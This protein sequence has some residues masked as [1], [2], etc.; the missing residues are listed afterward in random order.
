MSTTFDWIYLG[1]GVD[2][3]SNESNSSAD[4]AGA[5]VG[6]TYGTT[7][8]PLFSHVT[9]AT[10]LGT[11]TTFTNGNNAAT[12]QFSTD[13]GSGVQAYTYDSN[14]VYNATITY[15][16]GTTATVTAVIV[17]STTGQLFMAPDPVASTDLAPYEAKPI[18]AVTFNSVANSTNGLATDRYVTG[19]DDGYV[20]GTAGSDL[21]NASYV[22]PVANGTDKIDNGDAGL[23]GSSGNDD[24]V[25][26]GAGNDTVLSG[27]GNDIV[28]GG[29]ENDSLS[30]ETGNDT[31][32]G[33][34]GN[35]TVL[36]GA[37]ADS[38]SG[39]DGADSLD[40][41]TEGDVLSG[42]AGADTLRGGAGNDSLDGGTEA[43]Q[44]FGEAGNDTLRG[45]D[46]DDSLYGGTEADQLFGDAGNDALSGG[47]GA[48]TL[49][50]GT[51]NDQLFGGLGNDS[52]VGNT[53][54]DTLT[55]G[56]GADVLSAGSGMDYA[57]YT[58]SGAGVTVN[59]TTGTG[60]GGDAQGDTLSGVDGLFGSAFNDVLT[61]YD[62]SSTVPGDAYT[63]V[64]YGNAGYDVLSGLGG[65]DS[66]YGGADNDTVQG[67]AGDDLVDGGTGNDQLFGDDGA[68]TL[69][70]G[71]GADVLWGGTGGDL[72]DGDADQDT[73]YGDIGDTVT[74]GSAGTDLDVLD[75]T[76]WGKALTNVYKDPGNPETGYVEF[77]DGT[78]AVIGTMTFT[79]IETVIPCFT[80]GALIATD[81]GEV[82][83]EDLA[84]GDRV[85]TCDSGYQEIR[86]IGQRRLSRA[87]VAA[88]PEF[89]PIRI[90]RG[91]LGP[92]L[93]ERDLVVSPQHRMLVAGSRSELLFGQHEVL[94]AAR[95]LA[96]L[97]GITVLPPQAVTYIHLLF[98]QHE[99]IRANGAWT[100]SYQPG[101]MTLAGMEDAQRSEILT[102]FPDLRLGYLFPAARLSLRR[103]ESRLL[104]SA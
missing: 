65:A 104:M 7:A 31:L 30:G 63:N 20:D 96:G 103:H 42:G 43:D 18:R 27:A 57:D 36:G 41:G 11:A 34:T 64:F 62:G 5:L 58:A 24:F 78:G 85:L 54:D 98:D 47:D 94:V 23:T 82:A 70:G 15:A 44:L 89:A 14:A 12:F 4:N 75:L 46:G 66:L 50:G 73:I 76:S 83:V 25:R 6:Q 51:G 100:E 37:G 92:D 68:D 22:E 28:Y 35:D 101:E 91:A 21:I 79:D 80:P 10:M 9:Q 38:M 55:G 77:L 48:D 93:P 71:A 74:G 2:I 69:L 49:D 29:T 95:H 33:E 52:L 72:L 32:Y 53:G 40:G 8:N 56:A 84:T 60:L 99:I 3:D 87:E 61:G 45:G 17:Q 90:G 1:T 86:W 81:R 102:L 88:R 97:P 67:G 16:D 59:L 39:G 13:I 19:F 26:A